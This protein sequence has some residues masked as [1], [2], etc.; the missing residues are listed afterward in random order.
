MSTTIR[1]TSPTGYYH[2]M[3][4]GVGKQIIFEDEFDYKVYLSKLSAERDQDGI[5]IVAYCL[6]DNHVHILLQSSNQIYVSRYMQKLGTSYA[7]YYNGKYDHN[8][9]VFQNRYKCKIIND[10]AYLLACIRYIHSNPVKAG[11]SSQSAYQ[12]SS[13]SDYVLNRGITDTELLLPLFDS[14]G[15]FAKFSSK[16]DDKQYEFLHLD[17]KS[18]SYEDGMHIVREYFGMEC[19][20]ASFVKRLCKP[21]RNKLIHRMKE[22]GLTN[23]QIEHMTGISRSIVQR[24]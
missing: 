11:I 7:K 4:R 13:Y 3:Q 23:K 10:Q 15:G 14:I 1:Q 17:S 20:D 6:M 9:H 19:T 5:K 21:E 16:S 24:A 8:G 12:W 2:I 22:I 18:A